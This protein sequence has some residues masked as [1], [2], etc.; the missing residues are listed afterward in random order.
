MRP[1]VYRKYLDYATLGAMRQLHAEVRREVAR[2]E[3]AEHVKLGP[4]G[5]REIE[6]V[7]QALQLVRG[8]RDPALTERTT[9][10]VLALLG[11]RNLLPA[12]AVSEL[13]G[14]LRVPAEA[15]S[16]ACSTS[17]MPSATTCP[18]TPRTARALRACAASPAGTNSARSWRRIARRSRAISRQCSPSE[19]PRPSRWPEHPR[20]AALRASQRYAALPD[21]SRRRLDALIPALA[22]A[23]Q[24]TPDAESHA[25][26]RPRPGRGDREPRRLPR[27]ARRAPAGAR[28]RRAHR[29]RLEL[30]G[31]VPHPPPA[32]ARRAARRP[33]ALRA[34]RPRGVRA[35]AARAARRARRRPRAA[36][37]R[38]CARCTRGRCS[39]C[40]PR[41]SPGCSRSSGSPTISRRSPTWC[42][43][44]RSS[45]AWDELPRPPPRGRA[46]L[47]G[48]R[49]RQ[50]RR[51][52]ARLRLRPRHRLPLR[53]SARAGAAR[54]TARLA[55][56]L[57]H[58]AHQRA[59]RPACCSTPTSRC[60]RAAR[61][62]CWCPRSR[63]SSATRSATP[64]SGSTRR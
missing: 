38:C 56:R 52:G 6:F 16:T 37:E 17:T 12:E 49:L 14:R 60:G 15:S 18:R 20:L 36:H 41:T 7:A 35:P 5:I 2:R 61:R 57:Q 51:Q 29:R 19:R 43:R 64:G 9:L 13:G 45:C 42:S 26:A 46:A 55:Q 27:A 31:G 62:A 48:H 24:A 8:G 22:R 53:R 11:E 3:L 33:G 40:S 54:S 39:A 30:G 23:A 28:A 34:A 50:A 63:R 32:A 25:R 4:G 10:R 47:R 58:L 44:S 1:F 59:P 21:E